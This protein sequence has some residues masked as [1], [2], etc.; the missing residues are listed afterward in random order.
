MLMYLYPPINRWL[1]SKKDQ[2]LKDK[3]KNA[4]EQRVGQVSQDRNGVS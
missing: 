3:L 4:T 1:K 2:I